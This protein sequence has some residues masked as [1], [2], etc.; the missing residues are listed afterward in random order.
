MRTHRDNKKNLFH[1]KIIYRL[2]F[3]MMILVL[4]VVGTMWIVQIVYLEKNYIYTSMERVQNQLDPLME[5]LETEDL[6]SDE[7]LIAGIS[8]AADGKMLLI[9]PD[10]ELMAM[11]TY[12]H[13]IDLEADSS[14]INVW[15]DM[16]AGEEQANIA[17]GRTFRKM[18]YTGHRVKAYEIGIPVHYNGEEAYLILYHSFSELYEVLDMNRMQLIVITIILTLL[19]GIFAILLSRRFTQPIRIIKETVE[20]MANGNLTAVTGI[21]LQDELG[22][23]SASVENLGV[24]LQRVDIL[25]KEVI[26]NVSHELRAP[27]SLIGGY[28]EMVRDVHWSEKE[29]REED[30]NLIIREVHR[31]SEMVKDIL[32]YSQLQAGYLQLVKQTCDLYDMIEQEV[33]HCRAIAEENHVGIKIKS[34]RA[35]MP[36][37]VDALKITQVVRNLIYNAINHTDD[38]AVIELYIVEEETRYTVSVVNPGVPIPEEDREVIWERY[39]RSQHQGS[40]R[41]GTGIGLSIVSTI[42]KAHE[43]PYGVTCRGGKT[44]FWFGYIKE[45]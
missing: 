6:A 26:A 34:E 44:I 14:D 27:L 39:Q 11:Y 12:G 29:L 33:T 35:E 15:K 32:D 5:E 45:K 23:L 22:Q 36:V 21:K 43:M 31:M 3:I 30:L 1:S 37:F 9:G 40:R 41:Q 42:L 20:E 13:P 38:G 7:S 10:C 2:W 25:R 19:A 4:L 8:Q 24:E 16:Q 28:A 18:M 17:S